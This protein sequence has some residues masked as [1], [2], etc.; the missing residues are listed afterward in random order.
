MDERNCLAKPGEMRRST[1]ESVRDFEALFFLAG[2]SVGFDRASLR[3]F[4]VFKVKE[5][6]NNFRNN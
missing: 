4:W 2:L 5:L 6:L 3:G 1:G